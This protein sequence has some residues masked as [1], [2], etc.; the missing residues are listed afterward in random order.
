ME[1]EDDCYDFDDD[2][3]PVDGAKMRLQNRDLRRQRRLS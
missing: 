1:I 3:L 2:G